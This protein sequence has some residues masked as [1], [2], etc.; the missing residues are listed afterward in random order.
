MT[1]QP[2]LTCQELVEVVTAYFEDALPPEERERFDAH[3]RVCPPCRHYLD[4]IR[5]TIALT[6]Q[7]TAAGIPPTQQDEFVALFRTWKRP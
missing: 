4:Q 1:P 5:Q 6:G 2:A 3:L 7:V